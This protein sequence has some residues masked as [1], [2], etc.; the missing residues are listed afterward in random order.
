MTIV[1]VTTETIGLFGVGVYS[2]N[3]LNFDPKQFFSK[4]ILSAE[5]RGRGTDSVA[6]VAEAMVNDKRRAQVQ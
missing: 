3:P 4:L 2:P 1:S 6:G 5:A